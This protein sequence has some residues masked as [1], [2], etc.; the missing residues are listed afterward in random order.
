LLFASIALLP[1]KIMP[2]RLQT[3]VQ[4]NLVSYTNDATRQLLI[5]VIASN[6]LAV[7]LGVM[8]LFAGTLAVAGIVLSWKLLNK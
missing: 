5:R 8:V 7:D 6:S 1:I 4:G 2:N 3:V